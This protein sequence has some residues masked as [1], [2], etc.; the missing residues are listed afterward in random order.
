MDELNI[1]LVLL[2]P[3][4]HQ[5]PSFADANFTASTGNPV[6]Y[7]ILFGSVNR[8]LRTKYVVGRGSD[9]PLT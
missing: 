7:A 8:V 2:D 9:N 1:P 4:L 3:F 6:N 5:Y